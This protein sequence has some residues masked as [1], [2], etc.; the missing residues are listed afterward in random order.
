MKGPAL[1]FALVAVASVV[2]FAAYTKERPTET[3]VSK[4]IVPAK[5]QARIVPEGAFAG[6]RAEE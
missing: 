2:G 5:D 6:Y 3:I 1:I 4:T